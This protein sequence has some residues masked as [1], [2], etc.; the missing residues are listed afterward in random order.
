[1][2]NRFTV[3]SE[4]A[5]DTIQLD[6]GVILSHFDPANPVRPRSEDI[7]FTTSGGINPTCTPT[8]SDLAEDVD[9]APNNM[10]EYKH[11][12]SWDCAMAFT[13]IKFNAE[14]TAYALG[15]SETTNGTNYTKVVPRRNLKQSDFKDLWWVGDKANGGAY[16]IKLCNALSTGGLSIQSTKNGK[17][18]NAMTLT[19]HFSVDE[20]D[21]VPMEFYDIQ[22]DSDEDIYKVSQNLV[23]V[24]SDF[25]DEYITE[26]DAFS[27]TLTPATD[28][29]IQTV[30]VMMGGEDITSTAYN[31]GEVSIPSVSGDIVITAVAAA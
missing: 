24:T 28:M 25:A 7:V 11:L 1:M 9:N 16:A 23:N 3:I 6:A 17:G 15:A 29:T 26:G 8:Y 5:F 31:A 21:K 30:V 18:T 4:D 12:D 13:S 22:I 2:G 27:A 10:K 20:Q 14:N 19:G